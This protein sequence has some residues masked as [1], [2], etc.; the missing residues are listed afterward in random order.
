MFGQCQLPTCSD[1]IKNGNE[2]GVDCGGG[3]C[4]ACPLGQGCAGNTDCVVNSICSGGMCVC[5]A[6]RA[7]CNVNSVDGCEVNTTSENNNCGSCGLTC[8]PLNPNCINS[9]CQ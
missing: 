8:P 3:T 4:P 1:G 7:D 2:T 9:V 6:G 5:A